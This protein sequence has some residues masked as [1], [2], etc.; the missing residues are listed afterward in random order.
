VREEA[1]QSS[2][3]LVWVLQEAPR[4]E[5]AINAI[6]EFLEIGSYKEWSEDEKVKW[7]VAELEVRRYAGCWQGLGM[8]DVCRAVM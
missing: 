8:V 2:E 3:H 7:L 6:T 4:H 5:D 1:G